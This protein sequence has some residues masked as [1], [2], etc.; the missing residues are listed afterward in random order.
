MPMAA[1]MDTETLQFSLPRRGD[2]RQRF[3][4]GDWI[5]RWI[6]NSSFLRLSRAFVDILK[7]VITGFFCRGGETGAVDLTS[8]KRV[9]KMRH[10]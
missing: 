5:H 3:E 2:E 8:P 4:F 9:Q 1:L 10:T 6:R 7:V